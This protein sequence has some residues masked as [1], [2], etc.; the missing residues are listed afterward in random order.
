MQLW[1]VSRLATFPPDY[2]SVFYA[3]FRVYTNHEKEPRM[4]KQK[5]HLSLTDTERHLVVQC[6]LDLRNALIAQGKYTDAVDEVI[7]KFTK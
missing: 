1:A 5:Y 6:L 4:R 2:H 7:I 3:I